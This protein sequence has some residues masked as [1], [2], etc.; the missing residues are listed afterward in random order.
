MNINCASVSPCSHPVVISKKGLDGD[1]PMCHYHVILSY[2]EC[3]YIASIWNLRFQW[4]YH[5]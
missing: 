5:I 1:T 4:V 2:I 3:S